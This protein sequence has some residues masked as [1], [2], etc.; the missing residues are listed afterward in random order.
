[1]E[2][3]KKTKVSF[4][5]PEPDLTEAKG[6]LCGYKSHWPSAGLT[7]VVRSC[8]VEVEMVENGKG[9]VD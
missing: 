5:I 4:A 1:M 8:F 9:K 7:R 3:N 6:G 2:K